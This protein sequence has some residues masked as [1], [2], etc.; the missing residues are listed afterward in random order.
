[1][2]PV[3]F[4]LRILVAYA[5]RSKVLKA[6][7]DHW[8]IFGLPATIRHRWNVA[9]TLQ[10]GELLHAYPRHGINT[11]VIIRSVGSDLEV[12]RQVFC[13]RELE[14]VGSLSDVR[15]IIDAGANIGL[16]AIFLASFFP[17]ATIIALEPDKQNFEL[18]VRNTETIR[19]R[20]HCINS[21]VWTHCGRLHVNST[22]YRDASFSSRQYIPIEVDKDCA[23]VECV[24]IDELMK[25]YKLD[26]IDL[27]KIDIEGGETEI[28]RTG[29]QWLS[30]TRAIIIEL[31][32]DS[33]FGPATP[34]FQTSVAGRFRTSQSGEKVF[35]VR[36]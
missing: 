8:R 10:S 33:V 29:G 30:N 2:R 23:S 36:I 16:T 35:A 18:L 20:V 12:F 5:R 4:I 34:H 17:K 15:T 1:M 26:S 32:D 3:E 6:F 19:Q 31:H 9:K 24:T 7:L 11:P 21:A 25:Q 28:F 14:C 22:P 13:E 27:M